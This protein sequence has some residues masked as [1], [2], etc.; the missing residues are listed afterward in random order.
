MKTAETAPNTATEAE[1]AA[2]G[3]EVSD[4]TE[5]RSDGSDT[6]SES[7]SSAE[8]N[9]MAELPGSAKRSAGRRTVQWLRVNW[10]VA[11]VVI[12]LLSIS[13]VFGLLYRSSS[14]DVDAIHA[15]TALE[16]TA[17]RHALDYATG[18]ANLNFEDLG[19]WKK[20][21]TA[22]TSQQLTAKLNDAASS[23]EQVV[24]PLQWKSTATPI[25]ATVQSV[26]GDIYVVQA[27]VNVDTRNAQAPDGVQ[28][29]ATYTITLDG[30]KNWTIADVGGLQTGPESPAP[31]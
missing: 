24:V 22:N 19:A 8:K 30:S 23:M 17:K 20:K 27:F 7:D 2:T 6:A 29:T 16:Q 14:N 28:S 1:G 12:A 5:Q 15:R 25:A 26:N 18:A 10:V 9:S 13:V 31:R 4:E 21:L 3:S 11:S